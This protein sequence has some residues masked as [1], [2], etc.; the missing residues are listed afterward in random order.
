VAYSLKA[1]VVEPQQPVVTRQRPINNRE[2]MFSA[3]SVP[4]DE[5]AT[6]KYVMPS[7]SNNW[8]AKEE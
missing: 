7:L 4:M 2:M 3:Q 6:I 1:R 8:T 5:H